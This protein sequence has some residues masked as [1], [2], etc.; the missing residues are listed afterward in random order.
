M[1]LVGGVEGNG[2]WGRYMSIPSNLFRGIGMW[3]N[4]MS[5]CVLFFAHGRG[6]QMRE[7]KN[8]R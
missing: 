6:L 7:E 1:T 4:K 5:C 8:V 3:Y 2:G